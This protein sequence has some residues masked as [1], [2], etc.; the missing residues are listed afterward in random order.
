MADGIFISYRRE[1]SRHAAGRLREVLSESV[2]N[3]R[4]FMDVDNIPLGLDFQQVLEK[5][6]ARCEVM[7][8]V[9]GD[10]WL[11]A[12]DEGGN[13]RL[14]NANDFV[15]LEIETA[16]RRDI[17]VV[18]VLLDGVE[19]PPAVALPDSL[20]SL[21]RRQGM[22]ISHASFT[23]DAQRLYHGIAQVLPKTEPPEPP[24]DPAPEFRKPDIEQHELKLLPLSAPPRAGGN[25]LRNLLLLLSAVSAFFIWWIPQNLA[26]S[27]QIL[28]INAEVFWV[29]LVGATVL[30]VL[31]AV[32]LTIRY[33]GRTK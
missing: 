17:R 19:L 10:R 18:P 23:S 16:L 9:I 28:G 13:R 27:D 12:R 24:P 33:F 5:Q 32:Y 15:R 7:L 31:G 3:D 21:T 8:V 25:G 20:Q 6:L 30:A 4:L 2:P 26:P 22:Q 14:D 1:D 11:D 29:G